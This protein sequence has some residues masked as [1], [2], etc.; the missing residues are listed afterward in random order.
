MRRLYLLA[1]AFVLAV[2]LSAPLTAN[3]APSPSPDETDTNIED[4]E[5]LHYDFDLWIGH[6]VVNYYVRILQPGRQTRDRSIGF[7]RFETEDEMNEFAAWAKSYYPNSVTIEVGGSWVHWEYFATYDK[8]VDAEED[9]YLITT[10]SG[11]HTKVERV[12]AFP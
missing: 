1:P 4:L 9:A 8:R 11:F 5:D 6:D 7:Y 3:A 12:S 2:V 10:F